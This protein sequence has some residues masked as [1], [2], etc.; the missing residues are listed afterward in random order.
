LYTTAA[1]AAEKRVER[2]A[3]GAHRAAA[4]SKV[5]QWLAEFEAEKKGG[6]TAPTEP[7][8]ENASGNV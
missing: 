2:V 3:V 1:A 4:W 8:D 7:S 6:A 5:N